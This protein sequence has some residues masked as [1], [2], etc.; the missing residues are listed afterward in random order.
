M[1][2][3]KR[4]DAHAL[5]A[6][7]A[8]SGLTGFVGWSLCSI[9]LAAGLVHVYAGLELLGLRW[10]GGPFL[11]DMLS[12]RA[13]FSYEPQRAATQIIFEL[14]TLI[15]IRLGM[16]DLYWLS[17]IWSL[18]LQLAPLLLTS[19]SYF[20]LPARHKILFAL[21]V[22]SYFAGASS[23]ASSGML[24]GPTATAYFWVL[25]FLVLFAPERWGARI[26]VLTLAISTFVLHEIMAVLAP[27]LIY[28]AWWRGEQVEDPAA[29]LFFRILAIVFIAVLTVHVYHVILPEDVKNRDKFVDHFVGL[30]WLFRAG[31]NIPAA[32]GLLAGAAILA[33]SLFSRYS[34]AIVVAFGAATLLT[35]RLALTYGMAEQFTARNHPAIISI[36][37][38]MIAL[39]AMRWPLIA[40]RLISAHAVR[41]AMVLVLLA[42]A[43]LTTQVI[44]IRNWSEYT[45][46]YRQVLADR[47]GFIVWEDL[48]TELS[49]AE[50][51]VLRRMNFDW[52]NPSISILLSPQAHVRSMVLNPPTAWQQWDPTIPSRWPKAWF[53]DKSEFPVATGLDSPAR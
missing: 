27:L 22:F 5:D 9:L 29:K 17:A 41:S 31:I 19:A 20:V 21:P 52:T 10:D 32:L 40:S 2:L 36:P 7:S 13:F 33:M 37:L 3:D 34:T 53:Y 39:G 8:V 46:I 38:G 25:F 51:R 43:G 15:A 14:P 18:S 50:G 6:E 12:A 45:A 44:T 35:L 47:T 11:Q 23:V 24:E 26:A 16:T 4:N 48:M 28:A 49:P 1:P 30:Q 42:C